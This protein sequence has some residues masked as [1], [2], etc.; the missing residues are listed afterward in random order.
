M[1]SVAP[2][3]RLWN[4]Q[5]AA[6]KPEGRV[7]AFVCFPWSCGQLKDRRLG[8][9]G[10]VCSFHQA[11]KPGNAL[12]EMVVHSRHLVC[13]AFTRWRGQQRNAHPMDVVTSTLV[14]F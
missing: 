6:P 4:Q 12:V 3:G 9:E 11:E 1:K 2:L 10:G 5:S 8:P 7:S 13:R 14:R